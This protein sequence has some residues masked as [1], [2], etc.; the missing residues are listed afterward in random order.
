MKTISFLFFVLFSFS[1]LAQDTVTTP[2]ISEDLKGLVW[3]K[4][5]TENFIVLSIDKGQGL[6]IKNN[7]EDLKTLMLDKW[8]LP[9]VNFEGECKL[10][11]VSNKDLL[12]K[13]FR[14]DESKVEIRRDQ[15][16]NIK[17]CVIWFCLENKEIPLD[18]LTTI[19]MAQFEEKHG[20]LPYFCK[21]GIPLLNKSTQDVKQKFLSENNLKFS[22]KD[23][24]SA[25]EDKTKS[26]SYRVQSALL[27]L[28]LRKEFG[29]DNFVHFLHSKSL[30]S[31]GF[32]NDNEFEKIVNK[33]YENIY[34]DLKENKVPNN[35]LEIN[36]RR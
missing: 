11:C 28:L 18:H 20:K 35:Y 24:F 23:F 21:K 33:Y 15:Q 30:S 13:I 2:E 5:D 22:I 34:K 31:F 3:N 6:Y 16:G 26:E 14:L 27:C 1:L 10:I 4:W 12:K 32:E 29:Q 17:L 25:K 9:D 36:N 8:G 7:V 19:C